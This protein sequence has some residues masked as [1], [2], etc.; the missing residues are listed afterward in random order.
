[1]SNQA[2]AQ[3]TIS[4]RGSVFNVVGMERRIPPCPNS[5]SR[6]NLIWSDEIVSMLKSVSY[7]QSVNEER[8]MLKGVFQFGKENLSL[9]AT[10]GRRLAVTRREMNISGAMKASLF[11]HLLPFPSWRNCLTWRI[12]KHFLYGPSGRFRTQNRERRG[13]NFRFY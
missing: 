4:T 11:C 5:R 13:R 12:R 9:V 7:A 8:Y 1:M 2:T 3:A 10:D 6:K